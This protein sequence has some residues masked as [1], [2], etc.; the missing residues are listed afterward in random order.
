[1]SVLPLLSRRARITQDYGGSL[2]PGLVL[3]RAKPPNGQVNGAVPAHPIRSRRKVVR[4]ISWDCCRRTFKPAAFQARGSVG[5][6][7]SRW[8]QEAGEPRAAGGLVSPSA[9]PS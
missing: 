5:A 6:G 4:S 7:K 2:N 3:P 1:M 9:A 8:R